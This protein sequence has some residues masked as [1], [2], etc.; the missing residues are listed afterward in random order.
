MI[1][2]R[3]IDHIGVKGVI[4]KV[5]ERVQESRVYISVDIDVLDPA[6]A[7]GISIAFPS[8]SILENLMLYNRYGN[9]GSRRLEYKRAPQRP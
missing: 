9:P 6:F 1:K 8:A 5:K 2:A 4:E 7:P 3:D